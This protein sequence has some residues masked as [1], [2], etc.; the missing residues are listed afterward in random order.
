MRWL[1]Y[2][3]IPISDLSDFKL[4][5]EMLAQTEQHGDI[6]REISQGSRC[7]SLK[8]LDIL[9]DKCNVYVKQASFPGNLT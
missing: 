3:Q 2:T 4:A 5:L 6:S 7:L 8:E 1:V 9:K